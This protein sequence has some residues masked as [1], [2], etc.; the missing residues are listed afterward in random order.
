VLVKPTGPEV[1]RLPAADLELPGPLGRIDINAD[2]FEP[3]TV[4]RLPL[5][6][7]DV[8]SLVALAEA[9]PDER[10]EDA[11]FLVRAVVEDTDV[12]VA[13]EHGCRDLGIVRPAHDSHPRTEFLPGPKIAVTA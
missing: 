9:F 11:I 3:P 4:V 5:A 6:I 8:E 12:P 13:F 7:D 10:A 2:L 1:S